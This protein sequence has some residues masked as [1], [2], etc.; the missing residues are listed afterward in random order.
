LE[1]CPGL[2]EVMG[3][4]DWGF[5]QVLATEAKAG[6]VENLLAKGL[7]L[8][9]EIAAMGVEER[10]GVVLGEATANIQ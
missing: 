1:L 3:D 2:E 8:G 10:D 5:P 4:L 6:D 7:V 9:K